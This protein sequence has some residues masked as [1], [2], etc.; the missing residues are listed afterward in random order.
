MATF[1]NISEASNLSPD[2]RESIRWDNDKELAQ[3]QIKLSGI[4]K[5][6]FQYPLGKSK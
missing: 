2:V 6:L 1:G 5:F 3:I 4:S